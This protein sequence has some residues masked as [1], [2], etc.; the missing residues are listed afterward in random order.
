MRREARQQPTVG[1]LDHNLAAIVERGADQ[2][3]LLD[4]FV[5]PLANSFGAGARL[6]EPASSLNQPVDPVFARGF[7]ASR[8]WSKLFR[9]RPASPVP[10]D[11]VRLRLRQ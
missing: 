11:F 5:D 10:Q 8:P 7:R 9:A 6:A 1:V 4:T 2:R 3:N